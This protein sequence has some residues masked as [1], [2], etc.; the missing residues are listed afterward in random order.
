M[1]NHSTSRRL[2]SIAKRRAAVIVAVPLC[3]CNPHGAARS[4]APISGERAVMANQDTCLYEPQLSQLKAHP[5]SSG[6]VWKLIQ[7]CSLCLNDDRKAEPWLRLLADR[8]D[9]EAMVQLALAL[10]GEGH[11][12]AALRYAG[13]AARLG[14]PSA[15]Q[16]LDDWREGKPE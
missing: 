9:K 16:L 5:E 14:Y 8:R 6:G 4:A 1:D 13:M 11:N 2:S 3:C 7:H 10:K 12:K 15:R